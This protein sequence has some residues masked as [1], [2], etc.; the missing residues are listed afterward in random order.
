MHLEYLKDHTI[1][2]ESVSSNCD[3]GTN[4]IHGLNIL[5]HAVQPRQSQHFSKIWQSSDDF[6]GGIDLR[7]SIDLALFYH[8]HS[9]GM[10]TLQ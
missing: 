4:R 7:T 6:V 8:H 9:L 5:A 2:H 3:L 10:K 1:K